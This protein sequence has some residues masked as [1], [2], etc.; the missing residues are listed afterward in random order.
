MNPDSQ[1]DD[2]RCYNDA[3]I[4]L[5][6]SKLVED[7]QLLAILPQILPN[8]PVAVLIEQL[9]KV[10]SVD[11]FQK[12]FILPFLSD[13][14]TKTSK[15]VELIQLDRVNPHRHHLFISNHRDIVLDSAFLNIH[16]LKNGYQ[17]TEIAIGNNLL[18][19]PWIEH[20]VRI[21]KSFIV[22]R[23]ASVREQIRI[24]QELSAY[25]RYVITT[26]PHSVWLAQREGRAKDSDDRTQPALI[27]MLQMSAEGEYVKGI[28]DLNI[29]PLSINYEYD[30]CDYLKAKEFQLKRDDECYKKSPADDLLNMS[31]GIMG[32]KGRISYVFGTPL[33][34]H[35]ALNLVSQLSS[36][37]QST[38]IAH[39]IDTEIH[40]NYNLY[41][42]NYVAADLLSKQNLFTKHY[43]KEDEKDFIA[44]VQQ[45]VNKIDISNKDEDF[46][47]RKI[48]EMYANPVYNQ[49]EAIRI[50]Q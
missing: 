49:R 45:R 47:T 30:P 34:D 41:P 6:F 50:Q 20:L 48:L 21:N 24:S 14:E 4:P 23:N 16:L 13:L 37:E 9:K 46:L 42:C 25:I 18:I 1:F 5:Q 11:Q 28:M 12:E 15:G 43:S 3:E 31:T 19:Y 22:R 8:I 38:Y 29:V 36:K 7:K 17:T 2:I 26:K 39:L 40:R 32:Y 35:P 33:N 27:K 10:Q 44:Y